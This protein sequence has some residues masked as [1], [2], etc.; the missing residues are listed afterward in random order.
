MLDT[1]KSNKRQAEEQVRDA[2]GT[3]R[4]VGNTEE[5]VRGG[6]AR[7]WDSRRGSQLRSRSRIRVKNRVGFGHVA[8][9][10]LAP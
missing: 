10:I 4:S 1:R 9:T 3:L 8:D 7:R 2:D 5:P 6:V